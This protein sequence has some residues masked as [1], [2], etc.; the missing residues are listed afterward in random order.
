MDPS[1]EKI[2]KLPAKQ[3]VG[4]LALV[5]V[6]IGAGFFLWPSATKAQGVEETAEQS[7]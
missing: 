4:L 3:K 7:G 1:I 2:L 6:V 5:I